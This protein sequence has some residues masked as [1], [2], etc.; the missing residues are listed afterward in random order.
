MKVMKG[1]KTLAS[2]LTM[3]FPAALLWAI[4]SPG[5][6]ALEGGGPSLENFISA[7]QIAALH[8]GQSPIA[9]QFGSPQPQLAPQH[10]FL[11][12]RI[13]TMRRDL[14]PSVMVEVLYLYRKPPYAERPAWTLQEQARLYNEI[15]A[16]STLAGIQY[17]STTRGINRTLYETSQVIDG[18]STRRPIADPVFPQP[19][20]ELTLYVR[21]QDLTFGDNIY[22][23][24]FFTAP[25]AFIIT[26]QNIT[27]LTVGIITAV[28]R[29][30]LRSTIAILDAGEYI[31]VYAVSM[32]RAASLPGMRE[33]VGSSFTTRTKAVIQWFTGRAD[34][35]FA[36]V[37]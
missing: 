14:R 24:S 29:N 1:K 4:P 16:L 6:F 2:F 31:L 23:Y 30:N 35:A 25:G 27:A 18:P 9:V 12:S 15:L 3:L 37:D 26:Q 10:D 28:G 20:A 5:I 13:E 22:R 19:Q 34:K 21:Q 11:R 33:R 17:F 7:A 32:A 36:N 8:A